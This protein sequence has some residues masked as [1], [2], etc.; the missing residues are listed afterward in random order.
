MEQEVTLQ[1][2]QAFARALQT[3][4][5]AGGI[6]TLGEKSV[7]AVLKRYCEPLGCMHEYRVGKYVADIVNEDGITEIQT[8]HFSALPG[9][10]EAFLHEV[11][12]TLVH[13]VIRHLYLCR[14]DGATGA[15]TGRSRS[16]KT[17]Q[18]TDTIWELYRIL[19]YLYHPNFTLRLL[20]LD[21]EEIRVQTD[22]VRRGRNVQEKGDRVPLALVG[23]YECKTPADY[24]GLLPPL[25]DV[26]TAAEFARGLRRSQKRAAFALSFCKKLGIVEACG[27]RGRAY[28][29]RV[30]SPGEQC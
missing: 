14:V 3:T 23:E 25:P 9:K 11:P 28:L 26:F 7:H 12:V 21:A 17:G 20:L 15:L 27:T 19:P 4:S 2:Q 30:V 6:G 13:P 16:P 8:A 24:I 22:R 10:L 29:Y 5:P 18:Y 1:K